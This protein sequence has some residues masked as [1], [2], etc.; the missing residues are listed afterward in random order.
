A[1]GGDPKQI[2]IFGE[3]AGAAS[4][5]YYNYAYTKDP[6]IAGSIGESGTATSFGNKLPSTAAKN[7]F[8]V[9]ERV[10]CNSSDKAQ[11]LK[12]MRSDK[13]SMADLITA[14]NKGLSG[15]EAVLGLFGPTIDNKTVFSNYTELA[16]EG[17]FIRKPYITGSNSFEAGLFILLTAQD[18]FTQPTSFWED[19][20][21]NTFIC[22]ATTAAEFRARNRVPAWR[23]VYNPEFPNQAIPTSMGVAYHTAEILPMFGT[24]ESTTKQDSTWQERAMGSY[25]REAWSAF[26]RNPSSGLD[27]VGWRRFDSETASVNQLGFDPTDS[28]TFSVL[29]SFDTTAAY[30]EGCGSFPFMGTP[31]S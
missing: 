28:T 11:V 3:S 18:N 14:E 12:C 7:W 25:M 24:S 21:Q 4:V 23:Y 1:F 20:N 27:L 19:F 29:P 5:D 31:N 13:V 16:Q 10:G 9:A 15:L 17:R 6:I 30:D 26:A 22:P 8:E 2:T